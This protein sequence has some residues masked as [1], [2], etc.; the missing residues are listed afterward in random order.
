MQ[1]PVHGY[2][3]VVENGMRKVVF[4]TINAD[5]IKWTFP[6]G[7]L[8]EITFVNSDTMLVEDTPA[9]LLEAERHETFLRK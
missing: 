7:D 1:I 2:L 6:T 5:Q 3:G 4:S 9:E 8:T